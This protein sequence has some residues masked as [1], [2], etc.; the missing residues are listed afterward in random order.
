MVRPVKPGVNSFDIAIANRQTSGKVRDESVLRHASRA[1]HTKE[2]I[3]TISYSDGFYTMN[4]MLCAGPGH[5][6]IPDHILCLDFHIRKQSRPRRTANPDTDPPGVHCTHG[7]GSLSPLL[8]SVPMKETK[9]EAKG[10][11]DIES[12]AVSIIIPLIYQHRASQQT[13][14]GRCWCTIM[15][16]TY[17]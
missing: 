6:S 13:D 3:D 2:Q 12:T 9:Q 7:D 10:V 8:F 17:T 5:P 1:P 11:L 16:S 15:K 4:G 14:M